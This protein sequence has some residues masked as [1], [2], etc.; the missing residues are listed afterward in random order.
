M[1]IKTTFLVGYTALIATALSGTMAPAQ[2]NQIS[3]EQIRMEAFQSLEDAK[4][5]LNDY[6]ATVE[7]IELGD[8]LAALCEAYRQGPV[9]KF[10]D[11]S[12]ETLGDG[13]DFV[14]EKAVGAKDAVVEKTS[15][16]WGRLKYVFTGDLPK[17]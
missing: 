14:G 8:N 3:L 11:S 9:G 12:V 13:A 4:Q 10:V 1:I 15:T 7:S 17:Q 5:T 2:E 6:V 16:V